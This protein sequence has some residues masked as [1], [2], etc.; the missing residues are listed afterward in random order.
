MQACRHWAAWFL[1]ICENAER[2]I[3]LSCVI[4]ELA[5]SAPGAI[6]SATDDLIASFHVTQNG[7]G[8]ITATP[9]N[10][11]ERRDTADGGGFSQEFGD[12]A[13]AASVTTSAT[14]SNGATSVSWCAR[15]MSTARRMTCTATC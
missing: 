15:M 3:L 10:Y 8:N 11:T 1:F 7:V 12:A 6:T 4:A 14:W 9:T 5:V 13:G 2:S